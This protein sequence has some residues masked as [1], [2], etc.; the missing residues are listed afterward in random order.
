VIGNKKVLAVVTARGGSRGVQGKNYRELCG[1][2]LVMWSVDSAQGSKY[3]DEIAI[4]TNCPGVIKAVEG[5]LDDRTWLALR[6]DELATSSSRNE[7]ALTHAFY[8]ACLK[9]NAFCFDNVDII[10]NLQPTSPIRPKSLIDDVLANMVD[11]DR[12]S[13]LTVSVHTP[14][15]LHVD[16]NKVLWEFDPRTR[17]MRQDIPD[18]EMC[19]HDDGCLYVVHR[20][21]LLNEAC[22]LDKNPYVHIND[23]YASFQL[24]SEAD[25][26]IIAN[27]KNEL[28]KTGLY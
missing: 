8:M 23:P 25:F 28:D 18:S 4:S 12:K 1:K 24:D 3:I 15:F 21:V 22:R 19:L 20:D 14:F 7:A 26:Q 16:G 10:V 5:A 13:A 17:R 27:M 11:Q 2:P 9:N 6:P